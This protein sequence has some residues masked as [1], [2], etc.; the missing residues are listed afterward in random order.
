MPLYLPIKKISLAC[1]EDH[2][3]NTVPSLLHVLL[4]W[5]LQQIYEVFID[6]E[7]ET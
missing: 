4:H 6:E 2:V 5:Y 7:T 1:I 3:L